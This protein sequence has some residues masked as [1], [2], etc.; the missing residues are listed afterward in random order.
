MKRRRAEG[1]E[2]FA[3][4]V[5][6]AVRQQSH[7]HRRIVDQTLQRPAQNQP[8][9]SQLTGDAVKQTSVLIATPSATAPG[10]SRPVKKM[11]REPLANSSARQY[12]YADEIGITD[13]VSAQN[14][15]T[16]RSPIRTWESIRFNPTGNCYK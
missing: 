4:F 2:R 3:L 10:R 7:D 1:A 9:I 13:P 12:S 5:A 14:P 8:T 11:A 16:T 6:A 15:P